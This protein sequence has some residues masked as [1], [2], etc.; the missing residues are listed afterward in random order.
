MIHDAFRWRNPISSG[1]DQFS[2]DLMEWAPPSDWSDAARRAVRLLLA[3]DEGVG[4][5]KEA[6]ARALEAKWAGIEARST[7]RLT[8]EASRRIEPK[9]SMKWDGMIELDGPVVSIDLER[10]CAEIEI[11]YSTT[12]PGFPQ[13]MFSLRY[14]ISREEIKERLKRPC[15]LWNRQNM[16]ESFERMEEKMKRWVAAV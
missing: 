2:F 4:P 3:T 10:N 1:I 7:Y 9:L 8:A 5:T 15:T 11:N 16:L 12:H 13:G 14:V 6:A